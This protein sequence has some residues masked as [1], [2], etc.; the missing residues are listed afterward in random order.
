[1]RILLINTVCGIGSTGRMC[2][3]IY[4]ILEKNGHE[5]CIAY[6]RG[7]KVQEGIYK[8]Y[9]IGTNFSIYSHVFATRLF[10]KQGFASKTATRK[11]I[12]FID[13]YDPDI[14]HLHNVH[15]YYLNIELLFHYLKS[16]K[17][18]VIWTLHDCWTFS[19]HSATLDFDEQ[20]NL[21]VFQKERSE[22]SEYP[23]TWF[24]DRS[25][26]NYLKKK[27]L[28]SHLENLTIVTP[29]N[30]LKELLEVTFFAHYPV[31]IINN[32][33]DLDKFKLQN[34]EQLKQKLGLSNQ[35]IILGIA[36][37]WVEKKGISYF[38]ELAAKLPEQFQIILV[39]QKDKIAINEKIIHIEQTNNIDELAAFYSLADIFLNPTLADNFPTTNLESLACGTPV[40]TFRTG[41]SPETIDDT[42]GRVTLEKSS[43]ALYQTILDV[44]ATNFSSKACI[45]HSKRF[46]KWNAY[47]QYLRLYNNDI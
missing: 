25:K 2:T 44:L 23:A 33:I 22:L 8:T 10:D 19:G 26:K 18:R 6:G 20:N 35:I 5:C 46:D 3:D 4:D 15:G 11:F 29:S 30:W 12:N 14:I 39:G 32:G 31:K 43:D 16:S 38:N 27:E 47:G 13:Q 7:K 45:L 37:R 40:I 34:P 24:F 41:G 36:S 28:F 9:R 17:K 42:C 1:M 21:E